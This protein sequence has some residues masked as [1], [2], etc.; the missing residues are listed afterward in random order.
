MSLFLQIFQLRY[1]DSTKEI[2]IE[3]EDDFILLGNIENHSMK[4]KAQSSKDE[5]VNPLLQKLTNK[6]KMLKNE[7]AQQT[8]H[9]NWNRN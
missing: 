5:R 8:S 1:L 9:P 4:D 2:S 7:V 3:V 6:L